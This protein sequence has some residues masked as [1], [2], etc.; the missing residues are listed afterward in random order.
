MKKRNNIFRFREVRSKNLRGGE[1]IKGKIIVVLGFV[2]VMLMSMTA[3]AEAKTYNDFAGH[4]AVQYYQSDM[5]SSISP[6]VERVEYDTVYGEGNGY[7]VRLY[8]TNAGRTCIALCWAGVLESVASGV[9]SAPEWGHERS[10]ASV[11]SEIW[12]HAAAGRTTV[13]IEYY[14]DDLQ[15][16][17]L[18]YKYM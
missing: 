12:Q 16:W 9:M 8:L 13:H 2:L 5:S 10:A 3:T 17:E 14:Y 18:P 15:S 11:R 4:S 7:G 6:Y 1:K